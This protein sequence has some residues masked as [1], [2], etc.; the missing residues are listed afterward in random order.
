MRS[1]YDGKKER[2]KGKRKFQVNKDKENLGKQKK[3][4]RV[5]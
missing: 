3:D 2:R 4:Q 5:I 1:V